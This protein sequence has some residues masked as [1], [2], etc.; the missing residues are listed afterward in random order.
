MSAIEDF[1]NAPIGTTAT[2]AIGSRAMKIDGVER[3]WIGQSGFHMDDE[4]MTHWNYTLDPLVSVTRTLDPVPEWVY[5]PAVFARC[6]YCSYEGFGLQVTLHGPVLNGQKWE[7]TLCQ[8]ATDWRELVDVTPLYPK[9]ARRSKPL[10][11]DGYR[12]R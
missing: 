2:H 5:A 6:G 11:F 10:E 7:C 4:Q 3:R 12:T 8:T 1:K 9:G